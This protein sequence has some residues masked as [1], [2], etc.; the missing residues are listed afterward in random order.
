MPRTK[1]WVY[2]ERQ[3]EF[4]P[5]GVH[6]LMGKTTCKQLC[7]S[8]IQAEKSGANFRGEALTRTWKHFWQKMGF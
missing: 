5:L 7:A 6:S 1:P 8:K 3:K 4:C 2:K